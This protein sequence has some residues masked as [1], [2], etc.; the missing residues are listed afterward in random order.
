[1]RSP[2]GAGR[3]KGAA[4]GV[5][6]LK[7][8]RRETNPE[9]LFATSQERKRL[10]RFVPNRRGKRKLFDIP[11][12]FRGGGRGNEN[13]NIL[14]VDF[15]LEAEVGPAPSHILIFYFELTLA[16][17]A[18]FIPDTAR[19]KDENNRMLEFPPTISLTPSPPPTTFAQ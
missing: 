4:S 1:M 6:E 11:L 5:F 19:K 14:N 7:C 10:F 18:T 8:H 3:G 17:V 16:P 9:N 15:V 2:W 12:V 13:F